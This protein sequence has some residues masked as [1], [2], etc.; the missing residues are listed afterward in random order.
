[1]TIRDAVLA[2]REQ[3]GDAF[4]QRRNL[5]QCEM[6]GVDSSTDP[7][8]SGKETYVWLKQ[9]GRD[10]SVFQVFNPH[11]Q[12]RVGLPV[13]VGP[14]PQRPHRLMVMGVDW[15][16][17]AAHPDYTGGDYGSGDSGMDPYL[18]NHARSHE[19]PDFTPGAD[20]VNV[21]PRAF[22]QLKTTGGTSGLT[23]DVAAYRYNYRGTVTEYTGETAVSIATSQPAAGAHR[24]VLVYLDPLTNAIA[25]IAGDA[26]ALTVVPD[27]PNCPNG[28]VPSAYIKLEGSA[29]AI[30]ERMIYDARMPFS[31]VDPGYYGATQAAMA[32]DHARDIDWT[33]HMMGLG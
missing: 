20:A 10:G 18:I 9:S 4:E 13:L 21:Y 7:G 26:T 5:L 33:I 17:Q 8:V 2:Q 16:T 22:V 32:L 28:M 27:T 15:Q 24:F 23:V 12:R 30:A 6:V 11:V 29:T 3:T 31:I 14:D 25:S 1:M 19:Q